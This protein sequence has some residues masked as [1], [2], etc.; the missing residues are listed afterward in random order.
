[1]PEKGLCAIERSIL[2][3]FT[4]YLVM[5]AIRLIRFFL[6]LLAIPVTIFLLPFSL[7][8]FFKLKN[9]LN[10]IKENILKKDFL[11]LNSSF[12]A[13]QV[14]YYSNKMNRHGFPTRFGFIGELLKLNHQGIV[15]LYL[16]GNKILIQVK[17]ETADAAFLKEKTVEEMFAK[18]K[19]TADFGVNNG[20]YLMNGN[21]VLK[22]ALM[23]IAVMNVLIGFFLLFLVLFASFFFGFFG[24]PSIPTAG[25]IVL[26]LSAIVNIVLFLIYFAVKNGILNKNPDAARKTLYSYAKSVELNTIY[27]RLRD[28]RFDDEENL[29]YFLV[30]GEYG[31][32][33]VASHLAKTDANNLSLVLN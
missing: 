27:N 29:N 21:F 6:Y 24:L 33:A 10:R 17:K 20:I 23:V 22:S 9:Y 15:S 5:D 26:I 12:T 14:E 2:C 1:M 31:A 19:R 8:A 16:A 28:G 13:A 32:F 25:M 30:Y 18:W 7:F 4:A 3:F 11:E